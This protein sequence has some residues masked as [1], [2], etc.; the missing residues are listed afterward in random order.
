MDKCFLCHREDERLIA[1]F[2][3]DC[4]NEYS[5]ENARLVKADYQMDMERD[6]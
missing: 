4:V 3:A 1:G 5:E 2:C 6:A